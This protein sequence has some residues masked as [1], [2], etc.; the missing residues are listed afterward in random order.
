[1]ANLLNVSIL[2]A[3][4]PGPEALL[5][6]HPFAAVTFVFVQIIITL[7]LV[8]VLARRKMA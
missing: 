5:G 7:W 8:W 3:A 6:G 1:M 4:V 2:S